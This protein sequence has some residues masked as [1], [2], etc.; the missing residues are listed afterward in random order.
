MGCSV[1]QVGP[2]LSG[3]KCKVL[4]VRISPSH[5]NLENLLSFL[6]PCIGL[7]HSQMRIEN[8]FLVY[9]LEI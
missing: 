8:C 1:E 6:S 7:S 4:I 9:F 2:V 3:S 5:E